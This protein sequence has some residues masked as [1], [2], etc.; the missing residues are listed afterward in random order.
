MRNEDRNGNMAG[1]RW[2]QGRQGYG[3][4]IKEALQIRK[5]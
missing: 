5:A 4:I 2:T 3:K 1:N